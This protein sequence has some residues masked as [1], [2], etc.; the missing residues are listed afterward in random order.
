MATSLPKQALDLGDVGPTPGLGLEVV[1]AG[2][3]TPDERGR[4]SWAELGFQ[5]AARTVHRDGGVPGCPL[6]IIASGLPWFSRKISSSMS[7]FSR[8]LVQTRA[9]N[10]HGK[11]GT[12]RIGMPGNPDIEAAVFRVW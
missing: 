2:T 1:E 5:H 7:G 4:R 3:G 6:R 12:G 9:D 8:R 11:R 10:C